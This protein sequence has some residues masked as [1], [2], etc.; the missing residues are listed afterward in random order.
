MV[1]KS[2]KTIMSMT[3][4]TVP[5]IINY[6][7]TS[8]TPSVSIMAKKLAFRSSRCIRLTFRVA[9]VLTKLNVAPNT[10]LLPIT[11][12]PFITSTSLTVKH[13]FL[14]RKP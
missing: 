11:I 2:A 6:S 4:M 5:T 9:T 14:F 3:S 7:I 1:V 8:L 13:S 10:P 12:M